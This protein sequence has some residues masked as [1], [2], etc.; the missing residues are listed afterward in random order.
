MYLD[1][2]N[3]LAFMGFDSDGEVDP[4]TGAKSPIRLT[5]WVTYK[6]SAEGFPLPERFETW[7]VHPDGKRVPHSLTE[8]IEYVKY[9]PTADDFDLE[10]QFGVKPLPP[11]TT[12]SAMAASSGGRSW[13]WLYAGATVMGLV[14]VALV[15]VARRRRKLAA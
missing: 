6:A 4:R 5:G 12:V 15:V 1:P 9:T 11:G 2:A 14:T 10:K 3:D 13:R 7:S 8:V